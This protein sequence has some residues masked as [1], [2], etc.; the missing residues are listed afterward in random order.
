MRLKKS[1]RKEKAMPCAVAEAREWAKFLVNR[2]SRGPGDRE[3][4]MGRLARRHGI[5]RGLLWSLLYRPPKDMLVSKFMSL[6][7]AYIAECA[8]QEAALRHER[9]ITEAK[10]LLGETLTRAADFVAGEEGIKKTPPMGGG[11]DK[12]G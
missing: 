7:A 10:T 11:A 3:N 1:L 4:A 2:E 12:G 6:Q 9:Q 5:T 8:R